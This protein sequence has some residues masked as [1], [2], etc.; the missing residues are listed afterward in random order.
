MYAECLTYWGICL[1][2]LQGEFVVTHRT[3]QGRS[4]GLTMSTLEHVAQLGLACVTH[5]GLEV[6]ARTCGTTGAGLA[7]SHTWG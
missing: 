1:C 4:Y 5:M 7:V 3:P 2:A 6:R